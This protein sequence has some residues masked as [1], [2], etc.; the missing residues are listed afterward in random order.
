MKKSDFIPVSMVLRRKAYRPNA[1][2]HNSNE[3]TL[4]YITL[5]VHN[6]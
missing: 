5:P 4:T 6:A 1:K 2:Q 3:I